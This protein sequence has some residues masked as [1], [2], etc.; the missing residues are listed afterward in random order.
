[1][2]KI[3][4]VNV[5]FPPQTIGGATRVLS[6]NIDTLVE[7]YSDEIELVGFCTQADCREPYKIEV[8]PYQGFKVYRANCQFRM[9]MD[10]HPQDPEFYKIFMDFLATEQPDM[11][12]FH[13]VQRMSASVVEAARDFGVPYVVT[14]H[15]AW[16][17]SD[18][19]FL[20]DQNGKVYPNGHIDPSEDKLYPEGVEESASVQRVAYLKSLLNKAE[21]TL[22]VSQG[23]EQLYLKNGIEKTTLTKNGISSTVEWSEKDTSYTDKVVVG[24]IGGMSDHKG[25]D[26]FLEALSHTNGELIEALVVDHSKEPSYE[27]IEY[28]NSVRVTFIGRQPQHKIL[29]VYQRMDVLFAP[30]KWP[31]SFGL[32]TREAAAC[33]CWVVASNLGGIGGDVVEGQT[34]FVIE[35]TKEALSDV[36]SILCSEPNKYKTS[37]RSDS[38]YYSESQVDTLVKS[39]YLAN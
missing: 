23:F 22:H 17:I 37:A 5:F 2:K 19:Q 1:M 11:V 4:L 29:D 14:V 13:C 18:Y 34:G 38:L 9:N 6:D 16:W 10:W 33:G 21:T 3:A 12:H 39:V 15:D 25:Y 31:E 32:V 26:I 30:S 36:F 8:Y 35:P 27:Q 24:H 20:V 28:V 7:K